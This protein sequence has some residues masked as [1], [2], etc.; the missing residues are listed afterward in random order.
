M[1]DKLSTTA[2][3]VL[4]ITAMLCAT[5]VVLAGMATLVV[6]SV[7]AAIIVVTIKK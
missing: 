7:C 6:V 2:I 1:K 4:G 3:V 5:I